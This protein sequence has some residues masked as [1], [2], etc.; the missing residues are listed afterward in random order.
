MSSLDA[1]ALDKTNQIKKEGVAEKVVTRILDLVKSGNL[2]AGDRLPAERKLIE[3]FN[4]SRPTLREGLRALSIMGVIDSKHGGG[5]FVSNLDAQT[6]LGPIDFFVGLSQNNLEESYECRGLIESEIAKK[7]ALMAT[8]EDIIELNKM[9]IAQAS[10]GAD[11]IGFRILD[12][13]FHEKLFNIPQ[14][15]MLEKLALVFYN[16]GLEERRKATED[17]KLTKQSLKDH[18]NIVAGIE[19]KDVEKTRTAMASHL[20]HIEQ[21]SLSALKASS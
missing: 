8:D 17:P 19:A 1:F 20:N 7:C 13:K 6:L 10:I 15:G 18:Q 2:R 3:I 4:V 5:A 21:S 16:M 14:N 9:L 12:S 11:P